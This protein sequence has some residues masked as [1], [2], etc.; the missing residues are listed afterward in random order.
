MYVHVFEMYE[1]GILYVYMFLCMYACTYVS[2]IYEKATCMLVCMCVCMYV[3]MYAH[4]R[5]ESM[6]R[7]PVCMYVF[8]MY[9]KG[10]LYVCMY[11]YICVWNV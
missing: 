7:Q 1:K 10:N 6:K 3:C 11:V 2:T 5:V 4:M 8:G 9:E